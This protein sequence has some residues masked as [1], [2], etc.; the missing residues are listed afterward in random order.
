MIKVILLF[1]SAVPLACQIPYF[2]HAWTGSRLDHWDWI[3]YLLGVG[4]MVGALYDRKPGKFDWRGVALLLIMLI[5]TFSRSYHQIN[6][7]SIAAG[8]GV[9]FAAAWSI[10]AWAFAYALLPAIFILLMGTPSSSYH[11]SLLLNSP[12]WVAWGVKLLLAMICLAWILGNRKFKW[13]I[14]PGTFFFVAAVLATGLL[15]MH[16]KE[17]YF[18][19]KA[20]TP[21]F[22]VK[23]G[24]FFGRSI[25]PDNNTKR[26]FATS[27]V[28]QYRYMKNDYD[29]SVLAVKCGKNIHEIHPASHCLRTSLWRVNDEKLHYLQDNFAVTEID[30]QK[31]SSRYLVWVWFSSEEFS[32]PSFLGF[33]RQFKVKG[34]YFTYQISVPV[35]KNREKS[36]AVL[37]DFIKS[38]ENNK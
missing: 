5:L 29:I 31:G 11:I 18:T 21:D 32:T 3:Y 1:L 26:F 19:G 12:V 14:K 38:L 35:H 2:I 23:A 7:L 33:R 36:Q 24:E 10:G 30:A 37:H 27:T 34:N 15:L 13:Q 25:E 22:P 4:A 16:T 9:I 28:R 8:V 20:F 17:L 6:A